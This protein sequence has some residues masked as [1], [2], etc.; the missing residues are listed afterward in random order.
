MTY[1]VSDIHGNYEG[2][3][4]L[5]EKINLSEEDTLY[6]LG[7]VVDRG[8][9]GIKILQDMMMHYNIIPIIGNHEYMAINCLKFLNQEIT[10][11]SIAKLNEGVIQGLLE[12]QNV[13]GQATIDEFHKLNPEEKEDIIEYLEEF[14]SY[15]EVSVNGKDYILVH[16]GLSNFSPERPLEGYHISEMIFETPDYDRV[17]F[18]DKHLVTGHLPTRCIEG[19]EGQDKIYKANNH[20]A[21]DCGCACID[22]GSRLGC[23][24]LDTGEEF[25]V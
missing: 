3:I 21:I 13:G 22:E 10:E 14:S 11:E 17:Y 1:C 8:T 4:K 18:Q 2:Y 15:E 24:C 20:I 6:V 19:N 7:D 23:I 9:G 25:Y 16:A 12:W 5:L